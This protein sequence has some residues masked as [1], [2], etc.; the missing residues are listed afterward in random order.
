MVAPGLFRL[1]G[2]LGFTF[3]PDAVEDTG[4]QIHDLSIMN[5]FEVA[6]SASTL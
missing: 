1:R 4:V 6:A 2:L 3:D 5:V